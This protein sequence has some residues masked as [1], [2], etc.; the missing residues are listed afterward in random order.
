MQLGL[1]YT[2][3]HNR[4]LSKTADSLTAASFGFNI[5][6]VYLK[7]NEEKL[8]KWG[9]SFFRRN[10]LLPTG[11][12]LQEADN[13]YNYN[14]FTELMK[15][16]KHQVK[17]NITYRKLHIANSLLSKQKEDESLLGRT[18]YAIREWNGLVTGSF[19]Y[20]LGSGQEQKREYAY[21]PVAI[22]QGEYTWIDYNG[23]GIEELNEFEVA[24]FQD[25]KKYIRVYTPGN[26]YVK[27]NY[28]QFNYSIDLNPS[29]VIKNPAA[30]GIKKILMKTNTS[31]AL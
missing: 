13:S 7:S 30:R 14:F 19:L 15:N 25:Q 21:V 4:L 24:V 1:K 2:G 16:E 9:V 12:S 23:N 26:Q 31:S 8:N 10:D 29:A 20:E 18:E 17:F 22:G 5:Y 27:A 3:E 6:E 28:L 11:K